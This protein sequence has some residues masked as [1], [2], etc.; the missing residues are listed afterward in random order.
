M[1]KDKIQR[2][3]QSLSEES[4]DKMIAISMFSSKLRQLNLSDTIE[5]QLHFLSNYREVNSG[6]LTK[7]DFCPYQE[8][9][10]EK[11][12][13]ENLMSCHLENQIVDLSPLLAIIAIQRFAINTNDNKYNIKKKSVIQEYYN[14]LGQYESFVYAY[15]LDNNDFSLTNNPPT[16]FEKYVNAYN[17]HEEVCNQLLKPSQLPSQIKTIFDEFIPI[18]I[19]LRKE[20][21]DNETI[22]NFIDNVLIGKLNA[23]LFT[24]TAIPSSGII[25]RGLN[26]VSTCTTIITQCERVLNEIELNEKQKV[27]VNKCLDAWKR[28]K[29]IQTADSNNSGCLGIILLIIFAFCFTQF[30]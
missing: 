26:D 6:N 5:T 3:V 21:L 9:F 18:I 20:G 12:A 17:R 15:I 2:I 8:K 19:E 10:L 14:L 25:V 23:V 22:S 11:I 27:E 13:A 1:D 24:L 7:K 30:I 16:A 28:M 4:L 29:S